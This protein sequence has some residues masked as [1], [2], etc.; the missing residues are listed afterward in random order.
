[1]DMSTII[2]QL[3]AVLPLHTEFFTNNLAISQVGRSGDLAI[4]K[5]TTPHKLGAAGDI[6]YAL[7]VGVLSE[8]PIVSLTRQGHCLKGLTSQGHDLSVDFN[9][10][11]ITG[12]IPEEF[13]GAFRLIDVSARDSFEGYMKSLPVET[14]ASGNIVL[15]ENRHIENGYNGRK[16]ITIIDEFT[17]SYPVS[18]TLPS[19][20]NNAGAVRTMPRV[21]GVIDVQQLVDSYTKQP[22]QN[23]WAYVVL[24]SMVISKNRYVDR[25]SVTTQT[26]ATIFRQ[27]GIVNFDVYVVAPTVDELS[28]R[29]TRDSMQS[30]IAPALYKSLLNW[31]PPSEFN[32][33]QYSAVVATGHDVSAYNRSFLLHRF[34]FER[35]VDITRCDTINPAFNSAFRSVALDFLKLEGCNDIVQM[36]ASLDLD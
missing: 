34:G 3:H 20:T 10:I 17:F 25:D 30:Q 35:S 6:T 19:A 14:V 5:T 21:S 8:L 11:H 27:T 36:T 33:H 28:G 15:R 23:Y 29:K 26:P 2:R 7:V 1:M 18:D 13:N 24:G 22:P 16:Q 9:E 32:P 12:A 31:L 4:V